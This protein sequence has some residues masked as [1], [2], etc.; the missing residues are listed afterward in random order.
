MLM[1]L[2]FAIALAVI[3]AIARAFGAQSKHNEKRSMREHLGR[4]ESDAK[5]NR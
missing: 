3:I 2:A 4:I 1:G 5:L